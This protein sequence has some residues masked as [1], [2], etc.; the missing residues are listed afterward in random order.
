MYGCHQTKQE[1]LNI[2]STSKMKS[3]I[4]QIIVG[5]FWDHIF[6]VQSVGGS[7]L[8][9]LVANKAQAEPVIS[10]TAWRLGTEIFHWIDFKV[11]RNQWFLV[12]NYRPFHGFPLK[13]I[14]TK[15]VYMGIPITTWSF[16]T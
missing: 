2:D 15:S 16:R 14:A 6:R 5:T 10:G 8:E 11:Y 12:P 7:H 9:E 1:T 3:P 4:N 13:F